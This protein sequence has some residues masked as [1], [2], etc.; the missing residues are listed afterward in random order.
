MIR[1]LRVGR[2]RGSR[3]FLSGETV[4]FRCDSCKHLSWHGKDDPVGH[5]SKWHHPSCPMLPVTSKPNAPCIDCAN[6]PWNA[7]HMPRFAG[8]ALHHPKCGATFG[9][10]PGLGSLGSQA[11]GLA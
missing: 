2:I 8:G 10:L 9:G 1:M 5:A 6:L 11:S 7:T 4:I 3:F